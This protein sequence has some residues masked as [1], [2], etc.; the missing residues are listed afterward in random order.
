MKRK[1]RTRFKAMT[2]NY[3]KPVAYRTKTFSVEIPTDEYG[4]TEMGTLCKNIQ[5]ELLGQNETLLS[6]EIIR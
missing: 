2:G 3:Y 6:V 4:F 5:R 1:V